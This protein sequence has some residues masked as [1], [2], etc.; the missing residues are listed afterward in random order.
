VIIEG[1][2][3][4]SEWRRRERGGSEEKV[5]LS[6]NKGAAKL[7]CEEKELGISTGGGKRGRG[8]K[9]HVRLPRRRR[10]KAERDFSSGKEKSRWNA[11]RKGW[12]GGGESTVRVKR[13]GKRCL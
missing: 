11:P 10:I 6:D 8:E 9:R 4:S 7:H 2:G 12:G 5:R 13:R 3:E 1:G